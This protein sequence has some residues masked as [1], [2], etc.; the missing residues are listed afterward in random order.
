[1]IDL[2]E[3]LKDV[4]QGTELR[5]L[6][7]KDPVTFHTVNTSALYPISVKTS[8]GELVFFTKEGYYSSSTAPQNCM[9]Y[10][11]MMNSWCNVEYIPDGKLVVYE[12][13]GKIIQIGCAKGG[14][15]CKNTFKINVYWWYD[16]ESHTLYGSNPFYFDRQ[17]TGLEETRVRTLLKNEGYKV[18]GT[19]L[20]QVYEFK[21]GDIVVD[22]I[23]IIAIY[24][25]VNP[26]NA[27]VYKAIRRI[28]GEI[29][30]KTDT[31]IGYIYECR[32]ATTEEKNLF[33]NSLAEAGYSWD[34]DEIVPLFKKGD[35]IA[36]ENT[37]SIVDHV[38]KLGS[39]E[40]VIYYQACID[41]L[42]KLH[43]K[44]DSGV[45]TVER[46]HLAGRIEKQR[47][48]RML[49]EAGYEF[50]GV[51]VKPKQITFKH[52]EPVIVR[53]SSNQRWVGDFFQYMEGNVFVCSGSSWHFCLPYND[54]TKH[55]IGTSMPA[56]KYYR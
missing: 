38:A 41:S 43:V 56:P 21:K 3:I 28:N 34:G 55:L 52:F 12:K 44:T 22:P 27:I 23:G 14:W 30:V 18:S 31:G 45:G 42:G 26:N 10:P 5:C 50:D 1:M 24:D 39:I 19:E 54:D 49:A 15:G 32:L 40:N 9:L 35:I 20:K 11:P 6:L 53:D 13:N 47:I 36:S 2:I 8:V 37:I 51:N 29:V 33:F 17:V 46:N 48:L 25:H 16:L 4:P 7:F